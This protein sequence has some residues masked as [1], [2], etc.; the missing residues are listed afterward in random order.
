MGNLKFCQSIINLNFPYKQQIL[1]I[2]NLSQM[3]I[4]ELRIYF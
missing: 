4:Q 2:K 3:N 1:H